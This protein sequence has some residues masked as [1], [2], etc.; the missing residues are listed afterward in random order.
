MTCIIGEDECFREEFKETCEIEDPIE[1]DRK[2]FETWK[3]MS[4]KVNLME[5]LNI[6]FVC[7]SEELLIFVIVCVSAF[8]LGKGTI[9]S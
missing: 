3:N 8:L 6:S 2:G 4:K 7:Y 9:C 1:I 5:F